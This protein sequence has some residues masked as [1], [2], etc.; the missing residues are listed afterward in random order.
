MNTKIINKKLMSTD[1]KSLKILT[2]LG[3][4]Y[5]D[6]ISVD[7]HFEV[8]KPVIVTIEKFEK[9][10]LSNEFDRKLSKIKT[11]YNLIPIE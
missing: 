2:M 9:S 10:N 1:D 5:K 11:E 8:E 4:D 7:I 3:I 6:V